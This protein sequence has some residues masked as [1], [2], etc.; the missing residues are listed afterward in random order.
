[1]VLTKLEL[2][3]E[4]EFQERILIQYRE[5]IANGSK[6]CVLDALEWYALAQVDMLLKLY[7]TYYENQH[8][9]QKQLVEQRIKRLEKKLQILNKNH[10]YSQAYIISNQIELLE[11]ELKTIKE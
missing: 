9:S 1:M 2:E 11:T 10:Q 5:E 4:I 8:K 6:E 3:K 7:D